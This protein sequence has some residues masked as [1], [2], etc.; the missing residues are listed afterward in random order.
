[1]RL[2]LRVLTLTEVMWAPILLLWQG[3]MTKAICRRNSLFGL[4][5]SEGWSLWWWRRDS[6]WQELDAEKRNCGLH[7]ELQSGSRENSLQW[8]RHEGLKPQSLSQWHT[9]SRR[10]KPLN[11]FNLV[12][13]NQIFKH[14]DLC[15]VVHS[16]SNRYRSQE[17]QHIFLDTECSW[18]LPRLRDSR[19]FGENT[20]STQCQLLGTCYMKCSHALWFL[21]DTSCFSSACCPCLVSLVKSP[22][23]KEKSPFVRS[24]KQV[25]VDP[26]SMAVTGVDCLSAGSVSSRFSEQPLS[27][28]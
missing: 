19:Q 2:Y 7:L 9:S 11:L 4:M 5:I 27:R 26:L 25:N 6:N 8:E 28:K 15:G 1:M 24:E 22:K 20:G 14:L 17:H 3:T 16:H 10:P 18:V 23:T 12:V 21:S 13:R